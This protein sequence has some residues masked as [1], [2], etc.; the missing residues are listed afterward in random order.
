MISDNTTFALEE[1]PESM[2]VLL[3]Q[4]SM[5]EVEMELMVNVLIQNLFQSVKITMEMPNLVQE[6]FQVMDSTP[7]IRLEG[8]IKQYGM[9]I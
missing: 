4:C 6:N 9:E 8:K 5:L 7:E 1:F 2:D 3:E